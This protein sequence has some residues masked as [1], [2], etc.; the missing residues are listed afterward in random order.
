[1]ITLYS[2]D[3]SVLLQVEVEDRSYRI[4]EIMGEHALYLYFSLPEYIDIVPGTYTDFNGERY[5]LRKP[6]NFK[7]NHTRDFNYTIKLEPYS[8]ILRD[9]KM[10]FFV[11]SNNTNFELDFPLVFQPINFLQLIVDNLNANDSG[12]ATGDCIIAGEQLISFSNEFCDSALSKIS[13]AFN[14][15][16]EIIGKIIHLH[17][18]ERTDTALP[19]SYGKNMGFKP[20]L[21]R[22]NVDDSKVIN[23]LY[24]ITS[25]RNIDNTAYRAN[26]LRLPVSMQQAFNGITYLTDAFGLYLER[27]NLTGRRVEESADLSYIYP[28]RVGT[29]SQVVAVDIAKNFYNFYDSSI[30]ADLDFAQYM[31]AG[32][33]MTVVFQDG[34]LA[35]L[36]FEVEYV[37]L[38]R[39]FK[40][41][42][43]EVNGLI[44]PVDP[45]IPA[46]GDKYVVFNVMLPQS[47]IDAAEL[48]LLDEALALLQD[49]EKPR[50]SFAGTLD[51]VYATKNWAT[52]SSRINLGN[53][54]SF[55]DNQF[56]NDPI[57]IRIT[58]VKEFVNK[59][60]APVI[61]LSNNV[62]GKSFSETI[63]SL[64]SEL[65]SGA[66]SSVLK[67]NLNLKDV[68]LFKNAPDTANEHIDFAKGLSAQQPIVAENGFTANEA[69]IDQLTILSKMQS[70][71][72]GSGFLGSGFRLQ[73]NAGNWDL[74]VDSLVVR[75]NMDVFQL[76]I[77]Q[78]QSVG[79]QILLTPASMTCTRVEVLANTY[80]C[81]FNQDNGAVVNLFQ[82]NDQAIC[83]QFDGLTQKR[84][85]RLVTAIGIDYIELSKLDA[86]GVGIPAK[87]DEIVQLGH[88]TNAARQ[89]AI[90][91][92]S[93]GDPKIEQYKGINGF[94]LAGKLVTRISPE[95]NIFKAAEFI[96]ETAGGD[97]NL[98]TLIQANESEIQLRATQST[99]DS[100][101]DRVTD[102]EAVLVVQ[103]DQIS[104]KVTQT[105]VNA[106]QAAAIAAAAVDAAAKVAA[107]KIG[108][109]NI[110]IGTADF[111]KIN[112]N[113][114][115]N[116]VGNFGSLQ[117]ET[118]R[119]NVV[120]AN[121]TNY[122]GVR[123]VIPQ[124]TAPTL[125]SFYA[126]L[127]SG[128]SCN[129]A[130]FS[131]TT[132]YVKSESLITSL[133]WK[134][135][136]IYFPLGCLFGGSSSQGVVEF[137]GGLVKYSSFKVE[138]GNKA[139]DWTPAPEDVQAN[140]DTAEFNAKTYADTQF[141]E[142]MVYDSE[143]IQL[144]NSIS[145][146]V[147]QTAYDA[148]NVAI[149]QQ[150]TAIE[151]TAES[152]SLKLYDSVNQNRGRLNK[153][154]YFRNYL[155]GSTANSYSDWV[156]LQ[157]IDTNNVNVALGKSAICHK[158]SDGTI[159]ALDAPARVTDGLLILHTYTTLAERV[160]V[161]IDLGSIYALR[162][163]KMWHYYVDYRSYHDN[164]V[165]VSEDGIT[166]YPIFDSNIDGEYAESAAGHTIENPYV[167]EAGKAMLPTGIDII[168]RMI[169][170]TA[171]NTFFKANDGT[172]IAAFTIKD[173]KPL[174]KAEN[175]DVE[176]MVAKV[177]QTQAAGARVEINGISNSI[178]IYNSLNEPKILFTPKNVMS[179]LSIAT[180]GLIS[181]TYLARS[182]SLSSVGS[183]VLY[184]PEQVVISDAKNYTIS[185]PEV[186][187]NLAATRQPLSF[188]SCSVKISLKEVT[189]G[190]LIE[191]ANYSLTS[192][193]EGV[194]VYKSGSR[195]ISKLSEMTV[196]TYLMQVEVTING[197]SCFVTASIAA[198]QIIK[199]EA[200]IA[201]Q[202]IGIDGFNFIN[203]A[204]DY[205]HNASGNL[206][207]KKGT[208]TFKV[209][210]SGIYINGVLHR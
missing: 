26:T 160:Y 143:I 71:V 107:V 137:Y 155:N 184:A 121:P 120:Y 63:A 202:E 117:S 152:L 28:K 192:Y 189:S 7:K 25:D 169:S 16:F 173:G 96:V 132:G 125:I 129:F 37:H 167:Y 94:T 124:T 19:L 27:L 147:A 82:A 81:Y 201:Y 101:T 118:F 8:A 73:N 36:E 158:A 43:K 59:P 75:K 40:L 54:V 146:K 207:I 199:A 111:D 17:K 183:A 21:G 179:E 190:K 41:V 144:S 44:Y 130:C 159:V 53:L 74:E 13:E 116:Y 85:W 133:I 168:N 174:L 180:T 20:G 172:Q 48:E 67:N 70:E 2:P 123:F 62:T 186:Y 93:Y 176:N 98:H 115:P 185:T 78:I 170:L 72:F 33:T 210:S 1:M 68:F 61:E 196:G 90:L 100:L 14:T 205:V 91:I 77:Q 182:V 56:L 99:V 188:T 181:T 136:F 200:M 128:T 38:T 104:S 109:V 193:E 162:E 187:Y 194:T 204:T 134:Q 76:T 47:Y 35:G 3:D 92:S 209:T 191:L 195:T 141:I 45:D 4:R 79:G 86:D 23:R 46:I 50:Y 6:D 171:D 153:V 156:E 64:R 145:S 151:Q 102:T 5:L 138:Y 42:P 165:E 208:K 126:K 140:I 166:W 114:L 88:R 197:D 49:A 112:G 150:M 11:G 83:Q 52:I 12:W 139:T 65:I 164:K 22:I 148:N 122:Y 161:E 55:S 39:E 18:V 29:V 206:S 203:S 119:G 69:S 15:E 58:S 108:G 95:G 103:A 154:R 32:T 106:A 31:V 142:K 10:K 87:G 113:I 30:P 178:V 24:V 175:I 80:K 84:Y 97:Q 57:L 105:E 110:A 131:G 177:L 135:Y 51:E 149:S 157:A 66:Y 9:V 127:A 198:G 34:N 60:K 89:S 163:I